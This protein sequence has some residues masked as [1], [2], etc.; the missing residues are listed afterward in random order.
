MLA[1][2]LPSFAEIPWE[3]VGVF[4]LLST[5]AGEHICTFK[6]YYIWTRFNTSPTRLATRYLIFKYIHVS[7]AR[8]ACAW[9]PFDLFERDAWA[10]GGRGVGTVGVPW[11]DAPRG[12]ELGPG[13]LSVP[14]VSIFGTAQ[15]GELAAERSQKDFFLWPFILST[16]FSSFVSLLV[17]YIVDYSLLHSLSICFCCF[18][19]FLLFILLFAF[20]VPLALVQDPP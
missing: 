6:S 17:V 16:S 13:W 20:L 2:T 4:D 9:Q 8:E 15:G 5:L 1:D 14:I 11:P 10:S 3:I 12:I 7:E 18:I 19:S